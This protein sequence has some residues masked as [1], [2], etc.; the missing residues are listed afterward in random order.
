M[1]S[2]PSP[3][4]TTSVHVSSLG[5]RTEPPNKELK[6]TKPSIVELRS[7]TPVFGRR[8]EEGGEEAVPMAIGV[9]QTGA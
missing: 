6:L 9:R 4:A 3:E 5:D 1:A 2:S 7:L 8:E